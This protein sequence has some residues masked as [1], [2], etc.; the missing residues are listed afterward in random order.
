MAENFSL[1]SAV[2]QTAVDMSGLNKGLSEAESLTK[3]SLESAASGGLGR[4][5]EQA[6]RL[7]VGLPLVQRDDLV[8][9]LDEVRRI[10]HNFGYGAGDAMD[11]LLDEYGIHP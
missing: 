3:S 7:S 4:A 11:G 9:R 2:L 1:G 6:L 8:K 5:F 10:S